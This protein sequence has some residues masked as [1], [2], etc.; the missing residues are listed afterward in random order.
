MFFD[1]YPEFIDSDPRTN[2]TDPRDGYPIDADFLEK[3]YSCTMPAEQCVGKKILDLGSCTASLG[4]WCLAHGAISYTGVELQKKFVNDSCNNLA[5]YFLNNWQIVES[6]IEQFLENNN[7]HYDIVVASGVIYGVADMHGCLKQL[8]NVA[9]YIV[10]EAKHPPSLIQLALRFSEIAATIETK[11]AIIEVL[12]TPMVYEK[13]N[14]KVLS[15]G[16]NPSIGALTTIF[17]S[18]NFVPD[19]AVYDHLKSTLGEI[20]GLTDSKYFRY[21]IGFQKTAV[22]NKLVSFAEVYQNSTLLKNSVRKFE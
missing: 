5:K 21:G 1:Q 13:A 19:F 7:E 6:T 8:A 16:F 18:M 2:R 9:D 12:S 3:R 20:Y 11:Q 14:H 22:E 17:Q 4:A 10:I 15:L